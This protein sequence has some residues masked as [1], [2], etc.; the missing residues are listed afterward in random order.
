MLPS[1]Q[2]VIFDL[3]GVLADSEP[4]WNEID[5]KLLGE[6]GVNYR[7]EYH[8]N[9]V[10]VS[11]QLAVEFYKTALQISASVEDLMRRRGE[12]K[13]R[14]GTDLYSVQVYGPAAD[15]HHFT[16]QTP[17]E[18]WAAVE[19][20]D[21]AEIPDPQRGPPLRHE[22]AQLQY[23]WVPLD[24]A[25]QLFLA[26]ELHNGVTAVGILAA[27]A[28]RQGDFAALREAGAGER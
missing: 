6:H 28:A 18:R 15:L 12:I 3:D 24:R 11:Y 25:V 14:L 17:F 4:W 2:A 5:A 20:T 16:P 8:R 7:G 9:V 1:F 26:G 22:E 19:V 21:L 23:A 27:Y 10:G 13:N